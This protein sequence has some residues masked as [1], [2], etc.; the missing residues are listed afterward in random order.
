MRWMWSSVIF[1]G[2]VGALMRH[3][4]AASH[5]C[6]DMYRLGVHITRGHYHSGSNSSEL[7]PLHQR[8]IP[9]MSSFYA[10]MTNPCPQD[11]VL[12]LRAKPLLVYIIST[13]DALIS[14]SMLWLPCPPPPAV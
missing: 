4:A 14:V 3:S 5:H 13:D 10:S 11:Y 12:H 7:V 1:G 2:S 6:L 9:H 8:A